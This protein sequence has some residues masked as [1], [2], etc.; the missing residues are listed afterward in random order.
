MQS[1]S[2]QECFFSHVRGWKGCNLRSESFESFPLF[3]KKSVHPASFFI[4]DIVSLPGAGGGSGGLLIMKCMFHSS[5]QLMLSTLFNAFG[6]KR[7]SLEK[8]AQK[9]IY[10]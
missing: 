1:K 8:R 5:L 7:V 9:C 2:N 3:K 4:S 6:I 10:R